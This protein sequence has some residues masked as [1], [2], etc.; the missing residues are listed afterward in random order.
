MNKNLIDTIAPQLTELMVRKI[1]ALT[2][3]WHKPWVADIT[4]GLPRNLR[5]TPYRADNILLLAML[6]ELE[7][8][9]TPIFMTLR[10]AK[11]ENLSIR[12]GA[13]AFP[14]Y[15][16]MLY[17]RHKQT[18]QKI[19]PQEYYRLSWELRNQY[20][21]LPVMRYYS[22]F[23]IDQTD[24]AETHPE[25]YAALT[26]A[27][28]QDV[29]SDGVACVPLD[30]MLELQTWHCPIMLCYG[31]KASYSPSL[32]RIVCPE[33]RQFSEGAAFYTTLLHEIAHSTGHPERL[34]R[35]RDGRD[36]AEYAREELVAELTAA[37]CGAMLGLAT[38]P[39]AENAAYLKGWL[40]ILR[41]QPNFL[42]EIL[43]DVNKAARMI[44]ERLEQAQVDTDQTKHRAT[45]PKDDRH[46]CYPT[47]H[48]L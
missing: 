10:Q 19:E 4:H 41:E 11:D 43:G 20:D 3:D 24:M 9:R 35:L 8:F 7:K 46:T 22:V 31:D 15:F 30:R 42:F 2:D 18:R 40:E 47:G 21:V 1:E 14:V 38:T 25:R 23:N 26:A 6:T 37:L 29:D 36:S 33:K 12:K 39:R 32:D 13:K 5:G 16:W 48:L 34:N 44:D 28:M 45:H 27:P 17:I